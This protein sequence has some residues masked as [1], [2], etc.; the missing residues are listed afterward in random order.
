MVKNNSTKLLISGVVVEGQKK[1]REFGFP[2]ANI[3]LPLIIDS[4]VY[5]G[6]VY[7][8]EKKYK[9]AVFIWPDKL[10]LEAFVLDYNG[11]L[12]GKIVEVEIDKKIREMIKFSAEDELIEQI[13]K[14]VEIIKMS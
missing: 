14:D 12:Y 11:D 5:A 4:G 8:G 2:T 10:L 7:L 1:G 13:K 3:A 9:A 6:F